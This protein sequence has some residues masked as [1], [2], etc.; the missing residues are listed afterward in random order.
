MSFGHCVDLHSAAAAQLQYSNFWTSLPMFLALCAHPVKMKL[1]LDATAPAETTLW[2][3]DI[4]KFCWQWRLYYYRVV[5]I[6]FSSLYSAYVSVQNSVY[7]FLNL[8]RSFLSWGWIEWC[9]V[10]KKCF[11][12]YLQVHLANGV[13]MSRATYD[14]LMGVQKDS[15]LSKGL[16]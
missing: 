9:Y 12:M 5:S 6:L 14:Q 1:L 15:I 2:V 7:S 3:A 8:Y 11:T 4:T 16:P 10:L 13:L